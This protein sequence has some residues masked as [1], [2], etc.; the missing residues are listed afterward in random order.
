MGKRGWKRRLTGLAAAV[1]VLP[2]AIWAAECRDDAV[3][4]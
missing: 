1:A 2:G 3:Q 4:I